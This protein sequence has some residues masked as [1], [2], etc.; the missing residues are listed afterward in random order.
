MTLYVNLRAGPYGA[1]CE[2]YVLE[3]DALANDPPQVTSTPWSDLP[4]RVKGKDVL[5]AAHGFNVSYE[6]GVQSLGRLETALDMR[7]TEVFFGVLWPGD[8]MIPAINYPFE[9]KI[10]MHG[11]ALLAGFCNRWLAKARSVSFLSHSLGARVILQAIEGLSRP[12]RRVCITAGAVNADCLTAE[13]AASARDAGTIFTLSSR[14]DM[15]LALAFP[16]A[17]PI[18]DVMDQDHRPFQ[19]ALGREGPLDPYGDN[20]TPFEIPNA[21]PYGHGN[22]FPPGGPGDPSPDGEWKQA[23]AFMA[24]AFRGQPQTWP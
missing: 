18:A 4:G 11:G 1:V 16:L 22:Y 17:D 12:A 5:L 8:W 3:G 7:S 20:I 13:F 9:D 23:V 2:P 10:A 24:R 21:P 6:D 15:V 14:E 19:R